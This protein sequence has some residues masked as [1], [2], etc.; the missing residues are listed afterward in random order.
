MVL[1]LPIAKVGESKA[2]WTWGLMGP[3]VG[4][5]RDYFGYG[6]EGLKVKLRDTRSTPGAVGPISKEVLR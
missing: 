2:P 1:M 5:G 3:Y 4:A 6:P